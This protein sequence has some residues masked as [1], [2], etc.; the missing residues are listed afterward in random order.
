MAHNRLF[1]DE[2]V[3]V[4]MVKAGDNPES[5][6]VIYKSHNSNSHGESQL[7]SP[8]IDKNAESV[9]QTEKVNMDLSAIEDQDLRKAVEARIADLE[10]QIPETDDV[11]K[12][13]EPEVQEFIAKLQESQE[14]LQKQLDD[15]RTARRTAEYVVKAEA[16]TGLL[17]KAEEIGPVLADLADKAPDSFAKLETA[18]DAAAQRKDMAKLFSELGS[19]EGEAD[20]DPI[21]KR[22]AWVQAN[23]ASDETSEQARARFWKEHPD[24]K[25]AVK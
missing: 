13:A 25:E 8:P 19:G 6:V 17:G 18:L 15:E 4:G 9:P 10:A 14:D 3:S 11:A 24:E 23:K 21:A 5:E 20:A 1:V 7:E 2:L 16:F 12:D 22:D